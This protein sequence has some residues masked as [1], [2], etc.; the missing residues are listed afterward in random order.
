MKLTQLTSHLSKKSGGVIEV[1][2]ALH[3]DFLLS[4]TTTSHIIGIQ[5]KTAKQN[6]L[7]SSTPNLFSCQEYGPHFFGYA[8]ALKKNLQNLSPD[9]VHTHGLWMY[10]SW[11]NLQ[12]HNKTITP[13]I[14]TPHGMLDKWALKQASWKKRLVLSLFEKEH[15]NKCS[16]FH[17]LNESEYRS[18]REAGITNPIAIIPNGIYHKYPY[19]PKTDNTWSNPA[20]QK[21]LLF[22]GRLTPKKG[23]KELLEAWA[24][25]TKNRKDWTLKIAGWSEDNFGHKLQEQVLKLGIE[26]SVSFCGSLF[27]SEKEKAYLEADAF[28]LPSFSEGLPMTVL[29]AWS[30]SLPVLMTKECNL[31]EAFALNA[32]FEISNNSA[33]LTSQIERFLN[34]PIKQTAEI[35]KN[36]YIL[37]KKKYSWSQVTDNFR[38]L[39]SSIVNN[40]PL[41]DFVREN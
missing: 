14:I 35:A 25:F 2:E 10:N 1:I 33:Q 28:I 41:P 22:L 4:E 32:A 23:L 18:I 12:H 26:N 6:E 9:I 27:G 29:E 15:I 16:C 20:H 3:S 21:Q 5:D 24:I 37:S 17:A 36:G 11:A 31:S 30:F 34:S 19:T 7:L 40:G 38:T 8:P 13:Y 39:Y